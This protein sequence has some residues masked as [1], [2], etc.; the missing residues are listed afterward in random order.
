MGDHQRTSFL[1]FSLQVDFPLNFKEKSPFGPSKEE[2]AFFINEERV[3]I[4]FS[5]ILVNRLFVLSSKNRK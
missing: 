5:G 3:P 1:P 4:L 2:D